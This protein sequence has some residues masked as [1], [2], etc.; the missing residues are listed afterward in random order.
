MCLNDHVFDVND[1]KGQESDQDKAWPQ[2][3]PVAKEA[4]GD[5]QQQ[6]PRP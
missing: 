5:S 4:E 3:G 6:N 2:S 1:P